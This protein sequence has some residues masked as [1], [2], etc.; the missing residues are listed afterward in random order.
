M[1]YRQ[2]VLDQL[3][4]TIEDES[5]EWDFYTLLEQ[6]L[7]EQEFPAPEF[8]SRW[9]NQ[10]FLRALKHGRN[11][12]TGTVLLIETD[13]GDDG[14]Y[15]TEEF[16][17][18]T[19][20][21]RAVTIPSWLSEQLKDGV[22]REFEGA[23]TSANYVVYHFGFEFPPKGQ[24]ILEVVEDLPF[25]GDVE[26][27]L[28][29][30]GGVNYFAQTGKLEALVGLTAGI[31]Q[32][33]SSGGVD[34][35]SDGFGFNIYDRGIRGSLSAMS[36]GYVTESGFR[37]D[38]L[39]GSATLGFE[40]EIGRFGIL[41]LV[42][43]LVAVVEVIPGIDREDVEPIAVVLT[44]KPELNGS[45]DYNLQQ[46][47]FDGTSMEFGAALEASMEVDT[48]LLDFAVVVGAK[49]QA[50]LNFGSGPFFQNSDLYGYATISGSVVG[51]YSFSRTVRYPAA[52]G[53][54]AK[55]LQDP[56]SYQLRPLERA[57]PSKDNSKAASL[58]L[59]SNILPSSACALATHGDERMLLYV[60]D[61]G[62][63][64]NSIQFTDINFLYYN[65]AS[66][67]APSPISTDARA[68]FAPQVAFDSNGNAIAVWERFKDA[69]FED[70]DLDLAAA[71]FELVWSRWD[72]GTETWSP[73]IA[74]TDN[75]V[76][77]RAPLLAGPMTDGSVALTWTTNSANDLMGSLASPNEV[78]GTLFDPLSQSWSA[79]ASVGT[80]IVRQSSQSL[81]ARGDVA[82]YAW[83]QDMD[84]DAATMTD[85]ELYVSKLDSGV[86]QSQRQT[87]DNVSDE[88]ARLA[89]NSNGSTQLVW[90]S[91][92]ELTSIERLFGTTPLMEALQ[93]PGGVPSGWLEQP[94]GPPNQ[95]WITFDP[96]DRLTF[97]WQTMMEN[98]GAALVQATFKSNDVQDRWSRLRVLSSD[99]NLAK[100]VALAWQGDGD[101]GVA[102]TTTKLS[103]QLR[104]VELDDGST[105]MTD[106][107]PEQGQVDLIYHTE[108]QGIDLIVPGYSLLSV[109]PAQG[110]DNG[111]CVF[112]VKNAGNHN[113]EATELALYDGDP[114][115]QG[116]Q[117]LG[118][119][120]VESLTSREFDFPK[121]VSATGWGGGRSTPIE[122]LVAVIDPNDNVEETDE[123]NNQLVIDLAGSD[124]IL[125]EPTATHFADDSVQLNFPIQNFG[126]EA[127]GQSQLTVTRVSDDQ[128]L[129]TLS[130]SP[131]DPMQFET[132]EILL[133]AGTQTT[134]SL[135][136]KA[137]IVGGESAEPAIADGNNEIEFAS[138]KAF[139]L[140]GS[141]NR[142]IVNS[143]AA[144]LAEL[145]VA[146][147]FQVTATNQP[148]SFAAVDLPSGLSIDMASGVISGTTNTLGQHDV[149]LTVSNAEGASTS[150]LTIM[151]APP[152]EEGLDENMLTWITGGDGIWFSQS[153]DSFDG[154]DA[155]ESLIASPSGES[156]L[157]ASVTGPTT[158]SFYWKNG[159]IDDLD[160]FEFRLDGVLQ[161]TVTPSAAWR[162]E[163]IEIPAG[164]HSVDWLFVLSDSVDGGS[165]F[166][167]EVE[168]SN[169][170]VATSFDE[171]QAP[172][173]SSVQFQ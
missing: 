127:S 52:A 118:I 16:S 22:E 80:G 67:T 162:Q 38:S 152:P 29:M 32:R 82:V 159:G 27:L 5:E 138:L 150:A 46:R 78:K 42:P 146:F 129:A 148:T 70:T 53:A 39:S 26:G 137:T 62:S 164:V 36:T 88:C 114:A 108:K 132:T 124:L 6:T 81:A 158:L 31:N 7:N 50:D 115:M 144:V 113:A 101:L 49:W 157:G 140:E 74:L 106:F 1:S 133:P 72:S 105:E 47:A 54:S 18:E 128:I 155:A 37:L 66:W 35:K 92:K 107:L 173:G 76:L 41:N 86:W 25:L 141:T 64:A 161:R 2:G 12:I 112:D 48:W 93:P 122:T 109:P 153:T 169:R 14:E 69:N 85:S 116:T 151:V 98:E 77:D 57:K 167:D 58:A 87:N 168:F 104:E 171:F 84:G 17:Y 33:G 110:G 59:A 43:P 71:Q 119:W 60:A 111:Y 15:D 23:D 100:S 134:E 145:G 102:C 83:T 51:A 165:G 117:L 91:N 28:S 170:A 156:R 73:P 68:E 44:F 172:P 123:T 79:P 135:V 120:G 126:A 4:L 10:Q 136:L 166:I 90:K 96:D 149:Q 131:I 30:D 139:D 89:I 160:Q 34:P 97:V 8:G 3:V 40:W 99:D 142:P 130:V 143:N 147:N 95:F 21:W 63:T 94:L 65:G 13:A 154:V 163:H 125:H 121:S 24:Q 19:D 61:S 11:S 103:R 55:L 20:V 75:D 45:F 9:N 56:Q